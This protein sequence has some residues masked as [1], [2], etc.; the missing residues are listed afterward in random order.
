MGVK[1]LMKE[2]ISD[3]GEMAEYAECPHVT[4]TMTAI[5]SRL[6][7]LPRTIESLLG[8]N[9]PNFK[10]RLYLSR[11]P[12]LIDNG[13]G[14]APPSALTAMVQSHPDRF[15]INIVPNI[16]SYRKLIPFLIETWGQRHLVAT[17]DD[18]TFY[19]ADWLHRL[20]RSYLRLRCVIAYRGHYMQHDGQSLTP[21]R[22]WMSCRVRRNPDIFCLPT[23]KDG[24]L[25]D[26]IFFHPSVTDYQSA[27]QIAPTADDLW[28]KWHTA[29]GDVPVY[30]I[31]PDYRAHTFPHAGFRQGLYESFNKG[32]K[33]DEA[34][35][36]LV[37]YARKRLCFDLVENWSGQ[38]RATSS[39][40]AMSQIVAKN[41]TGMFIDE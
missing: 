33:N 26:T 29:A 4:V 28:F 27:L 38:N 15:Q 9:Y 19:P 13:I 32:G 41:K 40:V 37:A 5:S 22:S 21:Y 14:D 10:V 3:A 20:V 23:G 34:V 7:S 6:A 36:K 8:Q 31:N 18:D 39:K 24:V 11:E 16:G 30:L 1:T 12:F 35:E 25:Y 2:A 17:A